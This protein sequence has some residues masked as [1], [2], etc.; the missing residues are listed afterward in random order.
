MRKMPA[1]FSF[2]GEISRR[3]SASFCLLLFLA[4]QLFSSSESLHKWLHPDADSADHHCAV[5]LFSHGQVNASEAVLP[6]LAFVAVLFF[7]LPPL[8]SAVSFSF[9]YRFSASRAPPLI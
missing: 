9:D 6:L 5:T 2:R 8:Q 7:V 4:L 1:R 3:V